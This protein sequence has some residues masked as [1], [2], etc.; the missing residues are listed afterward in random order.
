[1]NKPLDMEIDVQTVHQMRQQGDAFLLLD[2]REQEEF[3][4]ASIS[5]ATLIPMGQL[6]ERLEELSAHREAPI[7]VHCHHGGRSLHVARLLRQAGFAQAQSMA[8]GIDAWSETI[9]SSVPR[10]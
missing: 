4:I 8:G 2:C 3:D 10:Y 6:G 7:V 5:G 9:D 1:M